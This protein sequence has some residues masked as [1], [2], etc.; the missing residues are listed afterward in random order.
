MP[1]RPLPSPT[2]GM[3]DDPARGCAGE[4]LYLRDDFVLPGAGAERSNDTF[5]VRV[6]A[7]PHTLDRLS[8]PPA[9][10]LPLCSA[11]QRWLNG[12]MI[13]GK[14]RARLEHGGA[15]SEVCSTINTGTSAIRRRSN[16]PPGCTPGVRL[17]H[18]RLYPEDA[19][20]RATIPSSGPELRREYWRCMS[21]PPAHRARCP[22]EGRDGRSRW[23]SQ[24]RCLHPAARE[25]RRRSSFAELYE[26]KLT[27]LNIEHARES[28]RKRERKSC[29]LAVNDRYALLWRQLSTLPAHRRASIRQTGVPMPCS[30]VF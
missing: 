28:A 24:S 30:A 18:R 9:H 3:S 10:W 17:S 2:D 19:I 13:G 20:G 27:K 5:V 15:I 7:C 29:D 14:Q 6:L 22:E 8:T 16:D 25:E 23:S 21:A 11:R 4:A 26:V 1:L 12:I